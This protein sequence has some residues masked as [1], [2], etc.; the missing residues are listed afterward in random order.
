MLAGFSDTRRRHVKQQCIAAHHSSAVAA[1][2]QP[3]PPS[4]L[5]RS[6][7]QDGVDLDARAGARVVP[8]AASAVIANLLALL[9][10]ARVAGAVP[11]ALHL[12]LD[13]AAAGGRQQVRVDGRA[14]RS[15]AASGTVSPAAW[16]HVKWLQARAQG[17]CCRGSAPA[18]TAG[19]PTQNLPPALTTCHPRRPT[20]GCTLGTLPPRPRT[21]RTACLPGRGCRWCFPHRG[22]TGRHMR[23]GEGRVAGCELGRWVGAGSGSRRAGRPAGRAGCAQRLQC[24]R[25]RGGPVHMSPAAGRARP[26]PAR[27]GRPP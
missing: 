25:R 4:P 27:G 22:I 6:A 19:A 1:A 18:A 10:G 20:R 14:G 9:A 16:L 8:E 17:L 12:A 21:L 24:P 23:G 26:G 15:A 11:A 13:A 7:V 3:P 2:G 5:S